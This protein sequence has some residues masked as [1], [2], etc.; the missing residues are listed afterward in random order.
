MWRKFRV[1]VMTSE[2]LVFG[3][4]HSVFSNVTLDGDVDANH[5]RLSSGEEVNQILREELG[6]ANINW[7]PK[8]AE[9]LIYTKRRSNVSSHQDEP[10]CKAV[11]FDVVASGCGTVGGR[12]LPGGN[13]T[14]T[15]ESVLRSF[16][17]SGVFSTLEGFAGRQADGR[18]VGARIDEGGF[19]SASGR[20]IRARSHTEGEYEILPRSSGEKFAGRFFRTESTHPS[21]FQSSDY[22]F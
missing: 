12:E 4:I 17:T 3:K 10:P 20:V 16:V 15:S 14:S 19:H 2:R 22:V 11:M 1:E 13:A 5:R 9:R 7:T 8:K 18:V 6:S 21:R